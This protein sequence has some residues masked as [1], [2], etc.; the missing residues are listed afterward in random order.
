MVGYIFIFYKI[1]FMVIFI[2]GVYEKL[3]VVF[4]LI[5]D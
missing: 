1:V 5:M 4:M 2:S 3:K